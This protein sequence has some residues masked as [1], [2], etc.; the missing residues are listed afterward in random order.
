MRVAPCNR[1]CRGLVMTNPVTITRTGPSVVIDRADLARIWQAARAGDDQARRTLRAM[2]DVL[3]PG[4][5]IHAA[6]WE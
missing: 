3:V 6:D 4:W 5:A 1:Y 2:L